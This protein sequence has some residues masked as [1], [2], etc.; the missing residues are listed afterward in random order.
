MSVKFEARSKLQTPNSKLRTGFTYV[1]I[2]VTL[3]LLAILIVP[4]MQL[5]SQAME[6]T[7]L[8]RD[9][10]T[11]ASL[12]RWEMERTRNLGISTERLKTV[13]DLTWPPP[14]DPPF[15]L[16]GGA[17]RITRTLKPDSDPLEVTVEVRRDGETG[18]AMAQ[19]VTLITDPVWGKQV[20]GAPS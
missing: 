19:L 17:W 1:E 3:T 15:A 11:A 10:I 16:N 20:Q 2:L 9:L 12:A 7:T 5:F 4:M 18:P 13:G 14:E 6:A 8:S